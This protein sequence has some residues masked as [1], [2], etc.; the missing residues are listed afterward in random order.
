MKMIKVV[1][2]TIVAS[3]LALSMF[4]STQAAETN[5]ASRTVLFDNSHGQTAGAADWV[6]DGGFSDYADS[7]KKQG[8]AVKSLDGEANISQESL[9]NSDILVIPEANIPFKTNEQ[10]AIVNF[11]NHGGSIIFI[12]DHYNADRNLNRIDTSEAMNGY[13]RGAYADM[14]KDMDQG[15]KQS[16]AMAGVSSSDW[17]AQNFGVRFRYNALGDL[18]TSNLV[19]SDESF[20]ITKGVKSVSM[21]AGSTLAIT[22]PKKAK[23]IVYTPDHLGNNAKWSHAV[24]QGV[25]NGGGKAEGAYIAIAKVGKGKAAFIGDS[26]LVEDSS[27]KYLREDTGKTKKTYDGF[28]E[29]DNAQLL[30]NLTSWLSKKESTP[31][32]AKSGVKL[33]K[34]TVLHDFEQPQNSTEPQKEPWSQPPEGYHWYD[35]STFAPGSYGSTK[36]TKADGDKQPGDQPA[37]QNVA[38]AI[39]KD[40]QANTPFNIT[41]NLSQLPANQ[42]LDN[43]KLGIYQDGGKQIGQFSTDGKS[44]SNIGY[45]SLPTIK[46][47]KDGTASVTISA[48]VTESLKGANI[49]LKQGDK[50]LKTEK[51]K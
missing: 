22:D 51:L 1:S 2:S 29:E 46:I 44:Y 45:G 21:H 27:P 50:T 24:D 17:L 12:S 3:A 8:F 18:N 42:S 47:N 10:Q 15:E 9:K 6:I 13:R 39:P 33:D 37:V 41:I 49:R 5:T 28:K 35:R 30:N 48:K 19:S 26:S 25:Y 23:G 36:S 43:L 20:G 34:A 38:F 16:K 14:T 11:V 32:L 40:V 7:M 4:P 31:N